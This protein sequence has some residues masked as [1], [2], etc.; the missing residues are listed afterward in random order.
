MAYHTED[1]VAYRKA[2]GLVI[3]NV[4]DAADETTKT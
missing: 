2:R 1:I 4:T 3:C